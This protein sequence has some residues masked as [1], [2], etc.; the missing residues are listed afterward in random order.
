MLSYLKRSAIMEKRD[1]LFSSL[2]VHKTLFSIQPILVSKYKLVIF[3]SSIFS[4][5]CLC[6]VDLFYEYIIAGSFFPDNVSA[7]SFFLFFMYYKYTYH[8][9]HKKE[10]QKYLSKKVTKKMLSKRQHP[11]NLCKASLNGR[12]P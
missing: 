4:S 7:S 8:Q 10:A 6:F 12:N 11:V 9:F 1:T 5:F 2:A 3:V